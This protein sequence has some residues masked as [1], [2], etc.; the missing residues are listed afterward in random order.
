M[1]KHIVMWQLK[2][3]AEGA[4]KAENAA[5]MKAKI[6]ALKPLIKEIRQIEL[7][8]NFSDAPSAF[9]VALY[10][11]FESRQDLKHYASHP[12]HVKV[13]EFI[14]KISYNRHVVD[15]EI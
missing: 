11:E 8:I 12:E 9:D 13:A 6:D 7:G 2:D 4:D 10:S 14:G 5:K 1:V 15:Y 3:H